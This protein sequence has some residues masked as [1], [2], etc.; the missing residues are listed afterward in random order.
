MSLCPA[1]HI[2]TLHETTTTY[3]RQIGDALVTLPN[4]L[5]WVCD[6]CGEYSYDEETIERLETLLGP[7]A[8]FSREPPARRRQRPAEARG[9]SLRHWT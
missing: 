2:G 7:E 3:V 1:C 5:T 4:V 9:R 8:S 6:I